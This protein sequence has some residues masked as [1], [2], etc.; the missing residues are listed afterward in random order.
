[1][2]KIQL[3]DFTKSYDAN[4]GVKYEVFKKSHFEIDYGEKVGLLGA[5]GSGKT[6]L[7]NMVSGNE[8]LTSGMRSVSGSISWPIGVFSSLSPNLTAN[9]N[10]FFICSLLSLDFNKMRYSVLNAAELLEHANK[11]IMHYSSGMRAK[12]AFFIALS[13]DFDFFIFDEVTSVGDQEFRI[14]ADKI[15]SDTLSKKGLILCSHNFNLIKKH[16]DKCY[17]I[18]NKT[19]SKKMD[20]EVAE[21]IYLDKK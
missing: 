2:K 18:D 9:Q 6:T 3:T 13:I 4:L 11:K 15:F 20:I 8:L 17:I 19:L 16:C 10:I 12:L 1:M 7:C 14:K 21:K 5:N